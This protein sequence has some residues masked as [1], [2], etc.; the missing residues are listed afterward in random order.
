LSTASTARS[1]SARVGLALAAGGLTGA[2]V[3]GSGVADCSWY[4]PMSWFAASVDWQ[5]VRADIE[6]AIDNNDIDGQAPGPLLLRL[7]W[8]CSGTYDKET[9]TGGSNGATMRFALESDDPANAGLQKAR[10]LLEP[11]K[12]KYPGMTFADLYTF[13]G[14]VAVESMGGPEIAWKPGRSD[15]ADE[16]FCP[17][18]GRLPDATQ[19]AAHIR[20]VFYRMGFNDQEIVALVGAHTVGHCHKDRSGFD[21]PWSF[22]PYSFDNDFFRLLFDET[23]TVRPNFKPTQYEDSTGKLM[24]LPTDLAIVQDPKFRQWAR[25]YADDM[26]LFHRDFAAAFAKLMDL[27]VPRR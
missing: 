22:G 21:G 18:N 24:M 7:A 12:A 19:G 13:A 3:L 20:Q 27:G 16:T 26:D 2:A 17:P 5:S 8:H 10:N 14:K 23:W 4:N 1:G 6:E 9:G 15:A 11:I 25:K